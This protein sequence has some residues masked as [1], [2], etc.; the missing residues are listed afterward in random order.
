MVVFLITLQIISKKENQINLEVFNLPYEIFKQPNIKELTITINE[1]D[2]V[3]DEM[4]EPNFMIN[5]TQITG[6]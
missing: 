2:I 5:L 3:H 4:L 6:T 1:I